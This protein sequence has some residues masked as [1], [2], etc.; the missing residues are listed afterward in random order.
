MLQ[1]F[2]PCT[3][4]LVILPP[5]YSSF[6]I[7]P[8]FY[9]CTTSFATLSPL[10]LH[11]LPILPPFY[12]HVH[13]LPYNTAT[14]FPLYHFLCNTVTI[15]LAPLSAFYPCATCFIIL[16]TIYPC[17]N[18]ANQHFTARRHTKR[19]KQKMS[20]C[21]LRNW[22][23]WLMTSLLLFFLLQKISPPVRMPPTVW[24]LSPMATLASVHDLSMHQWNAPRC[25]ES[26]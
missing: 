13:H 26:A 8:P 14:I 4:F 2:Y 3:T 1:P 16:T 19:Y 23:D 5:F 11:H 12:L 9:P 21:N 24:I 17:A 25:V 20:R 10:Y 18:Q 7:L 22:Y 15:V 6:I